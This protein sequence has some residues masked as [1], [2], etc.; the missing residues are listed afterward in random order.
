ML[1][2][3]SFFKALRRI[4][5]VLIW[6]LVAVWGVDV[7]QGH[8]DDYICMNSGE[9]TLSSA[10]WNCQPAWW[11]LWEVYYFIFNLDFSVEDILVC[12]NAFQHIATIV[13]LIL[14]VCQRNR[15]NNLTC[16]T[17]L[18]LYNAH[19]HFM[20]ACLFDLHY[21]L[22]SLANKTGHLL[23]QCYFCVVWGLVCMAHSNMTYVHKDSFGLADVFQSLNVLFLWTLN[24]AI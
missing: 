11:P 23:S 9:I 12:Q 19:L 8:I 17:D 13:L 20:M 2:P 3:C 18:D 22:G 7:P 15:V 10:G 21:C 14:F 4:E 24:F 6:I 16:C 1:P 5:P